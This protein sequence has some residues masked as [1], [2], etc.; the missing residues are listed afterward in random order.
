MA[1][2]KKEKVSVND[3]GFAFYDI[4]IRQGE[5][6]EDFILQIDDPTFFIGD[7]E[8]LLD[9]S[10]V[11]SNLVAHMGGPLC[12]IIG[13]KEDIGKPFK[14]SLENLVNSDEKPNSKSLFGSDRLYYKLEGKRNG[15]FYKNK[16]ILTHNE[17]MKIFEKAVEDF[18]KD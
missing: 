4:Q 16:M 12:E 6:E 14:A 5:H 3:I 1:N 2:Q 15:A 9:E 8:I 11:N 10:D 17:I 7:D 13:R 18:T